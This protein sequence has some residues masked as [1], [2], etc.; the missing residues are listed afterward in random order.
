[1][2]ELEELAPLDL[3]D[4]SNYESSECSKTV[5][6][7]ALGEYC[8]IYVLKSR[9]YDLEVALKTRNHDIQKGGLREV[10]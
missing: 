5:A 1:M 6:E 2:L 3:N 8:S 4:S 9:S 7:I 10:C